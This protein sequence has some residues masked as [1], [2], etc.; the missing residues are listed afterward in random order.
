[1]D[2]VQHF[3]IPYD[4][5]G[6]VTKFYQDVFGWSIS[7]SGVDEYQMIHTV[8]VD[9][10]FMPKESG[11]INGTMYPRKQSEGPTIVVTVENIKATIEKVVTA[12]GKLVTEPFQVA[13]MGIYGQIE[14]T[15]G[16]LW[17]IWEELKKD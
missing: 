14:D 9:E 4:D 5:Q 10:N 3:D 16:N 8:E 17:G 2:K 7:E 15:E 13:D 6:R 11:A 12:G 1:M